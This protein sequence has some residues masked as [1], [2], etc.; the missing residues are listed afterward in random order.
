MQAGS[1]QPAMV[2]RLLLLD[3]ACSHYCVSNWKIS[4][5]NYPKNCPAE[6]PGRVFR[7]IQ[8]DDETIYIDL[9]SIFYLIIAPQRHSGLQAIQIIDKKIT[10]KFITII[11]KYSGVSVTPMVDFHPCPNIVFFFC[12][13]LTPLM[14]KS[15]IHTLPSNKLTVAYCFLA[16]PIS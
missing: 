13:S 14:I 2:G 7:K 5:L 6:K 11:I 16:I 10:I 12:R 8:F 1:N 15:M 3:M 9:D 4:C